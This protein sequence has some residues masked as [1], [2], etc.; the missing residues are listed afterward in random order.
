MAAASDKTVAVESV[1]LN[2]GTLDL[3][4][5]ASA[6]LVATVA[7]NNA[8]DKTVTWTTSDPSVA[9][10]ANGVVT[11]KANGTAVITATA[12]QF[13]AACVVTV[14]AASS[15]QPGGDQPGGDQPGGTDQPGG[16]DDQPGED[17]C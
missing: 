13:S 8:T 7:P 11:A 14:S 15:D 6:T 16:G 4:V 2:T 3:T 1:A 5:G 17:R 12:G 10:V 9:E